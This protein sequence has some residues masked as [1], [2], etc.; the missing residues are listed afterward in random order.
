MPEEGSPLRRTTTTASSHVQLERFLERRRANP[1]F[2]LELS[3]AENLVEVLRR[4]NGFVPSAAG[5]ILLDDPSEKKDDRR[6]NPLTF[7]AAF[8]D[9]S[10]A[11]GRADDPRRPG[12]RRPGL[13][14]RRGLLDP[15]RAERPLLLPRRWTSRPAIRPSRWSPS[16]SASSSEVCGVLELINR[17]DAPGYS[18][19]GPQ[20]ARDLRRLHLDLD[21]ERPRRPPGPG[22]RQARQPDRPLQRPLSPHRPVRDASAAA[23]PRG[24]T[25]RCSSSTSTTSSGSTTPTAISPAARCCARWGT[26]CAARSADGRA[27]PPAT[28]A[29][30]SC[31]L[32]PERRPRG[33]DRHRRGG[34]RRDR[35]H[36]LLRRRRARSSPSPCRSRGITCS[37]GVATL[38]QHLEP[39]SSRSTT[40][41]AP[42]CASPTPPCTW[43]RR[44]GATDRPRRPAGAPPGPS[45]SDAR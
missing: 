19:R 42:S 24:W 31:S 10:A 30:S 7:I 33:G 29:T 4:A 21:P 14:D 23:R 6:Q 39:T 27:S 8:G 37:I 22:D 26:C 11:A 45:S 35:R 3:L 12:D 34:P 43:P 16:R 40:A 5:S 18:Q 2:P 25:S 17:C 36:H 32:L 1:N 41:R 13:P 9:K 38:R 28:A 44:P 20:P 15:V